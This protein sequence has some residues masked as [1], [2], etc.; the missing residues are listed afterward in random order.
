MNCESTESQRFN[1]L[2]ESAFWPTSTETIPAVEYEMY[3]PTQFVRRIR[4]SDAGSFMSQKLGRTVQFESDLERL[5][6]RLLENTPEVI[7]YAEQALRTSYTVNAKSY[8]YRP[9]ICVALKDGRCLVV[10]IKQCREMGFWNNRIKWDALKEF[11]IKNGWGMLITD[12]YKTIECLRKRKLNS[13]FVEQIRDYLDKGAM[14]LSI[15]R[16]IKYRHGAKDEDFSALVVQED[17]RWCL[18]PFQIYL[19]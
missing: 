18:N 8:F 6:F 14:P 1:R 17:L 12:G 2:I 5:F 13:K 15:Y 11:C 4:R 19:P 3:Y 9:D 16:E 10:E 7:W